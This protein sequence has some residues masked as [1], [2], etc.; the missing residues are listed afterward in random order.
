M[1]T[2]CALWMGVGGLD[3]HC[4]LPCTVGWRTLGTAESAGESWVC[5][6]VRLGVLT[7]PVLQQT[8]ERL[9]WALLSLCPSRIVQGDNRQTISLLKQE[10]VTLGGWVYTV[11]VWFWCG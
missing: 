9:H 4:L 8:H 10:N 11:L 1:D 2:L 7:G 3:F 5:E 6:L